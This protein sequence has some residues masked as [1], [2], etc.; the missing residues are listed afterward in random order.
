M[1][2]WT[3]LNQQAAGYTSL[4]TVLDPVT[5]TVDIT[6]AGLEVKLSAVLAAAAGSPIS[7]VTI[8]ADTLTVDT[9]LVSASGLILVARN[10][11]LSGIGGAALQL[12]TPASDAAVAELLIGSAT[13]GTLAIGASA[14]ATGQAPLPVPV[15]LSPASAFMYT[16]SADGTAQGQ[17][18]G[19]AAFLQDLVGRSWALNSYQAS[20]TAAA[21]LMDSSD[22]ADRAAAQ[23]M[24]NWI[25]AGVGT[26]SQSG[27]AV[28]SD[29]AEIY[30]QAGALLVALNVAPGAIFVPIL[31][32]YMYQSQIQ[33]LITALSAYEASL[34]TLSV[35]KDVAAALASVSGTLQATSLDEVGPLQAQLVNVES[36]IAA[37]RT[38]II[39]LRSDFV[40][41]A[42]Q[43]NTDY[44]S[45]AAAVARMEIDQFL[46]DSIATAMSV[47][48]LG[49]SAA[50]GVNGDIGA[51]TDGMNALHDGVTSAIKAIDDLAMTPPGGAGLVEQ[52]RQLIN[53]QLALMTAFE[54]ATILWAQAQQGDSGGALPSSL[55]VVDV[56][57][58]LAWDNYMIQA[59][60]VLTSVK[61]TIG[62]GSQAA[63]D[64]AN[65]YLA[66]LQVLAGYGKAINAKFV[67]YSSQA[68][69]GTVLQAQIA[70][71]KTVVARWQQQ[72][73][74]A[75]TDEEKLA[76][77][78]AI[79]QSRSDALK[80]S[81]YVAWSYYRSSYYYVNLVEPPVAV[82][83]SMTSA[84][85]QDA[86]AA[87][88]IWIAQLLGTASDGQHVVL[89]NDDVEI[90]F[91]FPIRTA[92]DTGTTVA[93]GTDVALLTPASGSQ[94]AQIAWTIPLG[95]SQ[96]QGVLPHG[97]N[98][99]IWITGIEFSFD[100]V[101]PNS[102][103]NVLLSVATSGTY[104]NG[105]GAQQ[106]E[107][108]VS[109]GL[110][111]DFGYTPGTG[112]VYIPW[113][114]PT[115]VYM[116]PTPYTQW[117]MTFYPD[118]GDPSGATT[119]YLKMQVAYLSSAA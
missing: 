62:T 8:Y 109:K 69:Q 78:S 103:G 79:L 12:A 24:F 97:G 7:S 40:L 118:G 102:K 33:G 101:T 25:V 67:A 60:S 94:P 85:L 22:P 96:L 57:P 47:V 93:A 75:K 29:F 115:A 119:L 18:L 61:E 23:Q 1:I 87:V 41:Q 56:D 6:F 14:P 104:E 82:S 114:I 59:Q 10:V 15:G 95:D 17:T 53:M 72:E 55:T 13:G 49:V 90:R 105:F 83:L 70:A 32:G 63:Q 45:L 99:A 110:I 58:S 16:L 48:S 112:H 68:A 117:T 74:E 88:S 98:V 111:G 73:A 113:Q 92:G 34:A 71:A 86:F 26:L 20:Y 38:S 2:D 5:K 64:A 43:A 51:L 84:Q 35:E 27:A 91:E 46:E 37:L 116:T 28:P 100:H 19:D 107:T 80:R 50:K 77:L 76:I 4:T 54:A 44:Q 9:A 3:S 89:P 21:T 106:S 81:I 36:N 66:T 39:S 52:A 65:V 30:S 42:D 11:D 31:S 108:F